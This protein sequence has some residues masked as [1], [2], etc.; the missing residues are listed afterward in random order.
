MQFNL[1]A[2][3]IPVALSVVV[4]STA[5][6]VNGAPTASDSMQAEE[7]KKEGG[8]KPLSAAMK[9]MGFNFKRSISAKTLDELQ[10]Y[11]DEF[12]A[13]AEKAKKAG[14]S[15]D[16]EAF[17]TGVS[18]LLTSLSSVQ[19]AINA[20]DLDL[21]KNRMKALNDIKKQYHGKFDV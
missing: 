9:T 19:D 4:L 2:V 10:G 14:Y 15:E 20:G 16:P 13:Y 12:H 1:K 6:I 7:I 21:A 3:L 11:V 8:S 18:E 5:Y 17:Q